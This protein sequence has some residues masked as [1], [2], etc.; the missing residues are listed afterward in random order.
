MTYSSEQACELKGMNMDRIE[1]W[2]PRWKDRVVLIAQYKVAKGNNQIV[3]TKTPT[4]D[5]MVFELEDTFIKECPIDT[6]G[7]IRCYAVPLDEVL[8]HKVELA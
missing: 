7:K 4:L 6:N 1:I 5:G 2:Q 3:F 8:S